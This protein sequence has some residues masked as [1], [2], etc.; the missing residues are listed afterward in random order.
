MQTSRVRTLLAFLN[1]SVLSLTAGFALVALLLAPASAGGL[2]FTV[3]SNL[4]DTDAGG[5]EPT[6]GDCTLREAIDAA[7]VDNSTDV[8]EFALGAGTPTIDVSAG[9]L[10]AIT[11]PV[12]IDG[13]TGGATRVE[14][15]GGAAGAGAD[16]LRITGGT[17]STIRALVINGFSDNGIEIVGPSGGN[18]IEGSYIGTNAAGTAA[19]VNTGDGVVVTGSANN[20][21]G[22]LTDSQRNLLSGNDDG[23]FSVGVRISGAGSTGN[24]VQGN[25][26]GTDVTGTIAIRNINGV[27][28]TSGATGNT[29]GGTTAAARNIISGNLGDGV[30]IAG[31]NTAGGNFVQGNFIGTKVTGM[32]ELHNGFFAVRISQS[33]G[34]FIGGTTGTT[35]G[36]ACTGA[37]NVLSG[38]FALSQVFI[39]APASTGNTIQGNFIG[40]NA[41]GTGTLPAGED[42]VRIE[43]ASNT[44]IGGTTPAARNVISGN[45]RKGVH[46]MSSSGYGYPLTTGIVV[47]GNFIGTDTTGT[48]DLGNWDY[49]VWLDGPSVSGNKIGGTAPGEGNVIAFNNPGVLAESDT[50]GNAIL[51]N[52]IFG[53]KSQSDQNALGI[54]LGGDSVTANDEDDPD[55][56]ANNLQNYPVLTSATSGSTRIQGTLNSTPATLFRIEFFSNDACDPFGYGEGKTFI[57]FTDAMTDGSG[58]AAF[59]VTFP[60]TVAPG[61]VITSTATDP[62]NN[63]SEFSACLA[64]VAGATPTPTPSPTPDGQTPTPT[65]TPTPTGQTPTP[66]PTPIETPT[67]TPI[68]Q[69]PTPTPIGQTPT[70]TPSPTPVG[71]T[72]TPTATASP[73]PSPATLTATTTPSPT[74]GGQTIVWGDANCSGGA[75]PVDSLITLRFDAGLSTNTGDCPAMGDTVDVLDASLHPWGDVDCGGE[76]NPVDSLKLLRFD[77]GLTVTQPAACPEIGADVAIVQPPA[78]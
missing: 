9:G 54:N 38:N 51:G 15:D 25:F 30:Q 5:C 31:Q 26:I 64:V 63:T 77:A 59:D 10:P 34:N 46:I 60:T 6:P 66:S 47:Q 41:L 14:L 24:Q 11:Q 65:P 32:T 4:D 49:G 20:T 18:K 72:P 43:G 70:L 37:C 12:T 13:N 33:P 45:P 29:I 21:I 56:G 55:T 78:S 36:G 16:G 2:T 68:G 62:G 52:S 67:P 44:I 1:A 42:G 28:I 8:I 39:G 23:N 75:D 17:G 40:L 35:P 7:N 22:G 50:T 73:S 76:V 69:T 19:V 58:D 57:G 53:S 61:E 27:L 3:N 71:Q 74:D 48:Q